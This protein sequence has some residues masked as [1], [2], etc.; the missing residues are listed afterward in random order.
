MNDSDLNGMLRRA[1]S[2]APAAMPSSL[3][4]SIMARVKVDDGRTKRWRSFVQWLLVLALVTG[5][6]T[7]GMI[8][9]TLASRDTTHAVPPTMKLFREGVQP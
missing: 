9:W 1:A 8:C 3:E 6:I 2:A 7:A 5:A 4:K